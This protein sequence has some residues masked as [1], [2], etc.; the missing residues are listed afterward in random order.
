[1]ITTC[2]IPDHAVELESIGFFERCDACA[3]AQFPPRT[4]CA[5]SLAD[6]LT[7]ASRRA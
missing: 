3:R 1:M 5:A 7:G 6:A 2:S 4:R